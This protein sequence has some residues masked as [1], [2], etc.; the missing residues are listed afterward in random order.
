MKAAAGEID[1]AAPGASVG[2]GGSSVLATPSSK[3]PSSN[4]SA[5]SKIAGEACNRR[6]NKTG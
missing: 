3:T 1:G 6:F 4:S 5:S 2:D